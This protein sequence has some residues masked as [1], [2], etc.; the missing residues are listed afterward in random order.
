MSSFKQIAEN[1]LVKQW[2]QFIV[3]NLLIK[4][5]G[6]DFSSDLDLDGFSNYKSPCWLKV[7]QWFREKQAKC[8]G[9]LSANA[10]MRIL[11]F[12]ALSEKFGSE[13]ILNNT[14]W[15]IKKNYLK[16]WTE[17]E[18]WT[19]CPRWKRWLW[20][21]GHILFFSR[22]RTNKD[23]SKLGDKREA[24]FYGNGPW[25]TTTTK[26]H[27]FS[28]TT[29]ANPD[30][31]MVKA[32]II[33]KSCFF[34]VELSIFTAVQCAQSL[35]CILCRGGSSSQK[36]NSGKTTLQ[37]WSQVSSQKTLGGIVTMIIQS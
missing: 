32:N 31:S 36:P 25:K 22:F 1:I 11:N 15:S 29:L 8:H 30:W 12:V 4:M 6:A 37:F 5:H 20:E 28:I 34:L 33:I 14:K 9:K 21:R 3:Q 17:W 7:I 18:F 26:C 27:P 16:L 23:E 10:R 24:H 35:I 19:L 13:K 2:L